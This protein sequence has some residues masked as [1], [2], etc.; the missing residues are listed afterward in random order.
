MFKQP[1]Q[2]KRDIR[3]GRSVNTLVLSLSF[4][5]WWHGKQR[6]VFAMGLVVGGMQKDHAVIHSKAKAGACH[7]TLWAVC[8]V[9][10]D[11]RRFV[12]GE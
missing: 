1:Y 8:G 12:R 7:F 10:L 4:L 11:H 9:C 3:F 5:Y 2:G 6:S